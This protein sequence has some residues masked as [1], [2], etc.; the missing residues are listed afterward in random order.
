MYLETIGTTPILFHSMITYVKTKRNFI[1]SGIY[2]PQLMK[3][4]AL[5]G[6]T[7]NRRGEW[8]TT[9]N[10]LDNGQYPRYITVKDE[11]ATKES[12][13]ITLTDHFID[14]LV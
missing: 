12:A 2:D 14:W 11:L 6:Y 8:V 4:F 5:C 3:P 7:Q 13:L 1:D 9:I 10:R